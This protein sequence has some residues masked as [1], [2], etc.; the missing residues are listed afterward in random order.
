MPNSSYSRAEGQGYNSNAESPSSPP[1][2]S[3]FEALVGSNH[4]DPIPVVALNVRKFSSLTP[5]L[6]CPTQPRE[7]SL[8]FAR[9]RSELSSRTWSGLGFASIFSQRW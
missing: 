9:C 2:S 3:S 5:I 4:F 6:R 1:F 7:E 8:D